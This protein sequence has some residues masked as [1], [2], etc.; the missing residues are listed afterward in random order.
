[1]QIWQHGLSYRGLKERI[2][3]A[4]AMPRPLS[5]EWCEQGRAVGK[6]KGVHLGTGGRGGDNRTEGLRESVP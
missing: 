2:N 4:G 5:A 1:M 6:H 3:V